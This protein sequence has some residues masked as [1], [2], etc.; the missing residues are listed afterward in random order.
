MSYDKR[1]VQREIIEI[2]REVP[3]INHAVK[4][5]GL[6][7]MTFYR[8]MKID[9]HFYYNVNSA[10][11]EGHKNLNELAESL[12]M[13]KV[14]EGNLNAIKFYLENN[15]GKYMNRKFRLETRYDRN[16]ADASEPVHTRIPEN[17]VL[18]EDE[19]DRFAKILQ[20]SKELNL[21][22]Y[23]KERYLEMIVT[24]T[25]DDYVKDFN[26]KRENTGENTTPITQ[27]PQ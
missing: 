5:V 10:T 20:L 23:E 24:G 1:K 4:K 11:E 3:F 15:H 6:S 19:T 21:S 9:T 2:L 22:Q 17:L 25:F 7:R 12:L 13:K 27:E 26:N 8:W 16:I 18:D 14:R